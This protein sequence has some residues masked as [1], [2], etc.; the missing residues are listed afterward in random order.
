[1]LS[2]MMMPH[3]SQ[4]AAFREAFVSNDFVKAET[5]ALKTTRAA[6]GS[7]TDTAWSFTLRSGGINSY[8]AARKKTNKTV[9][10]VRVKRC[11]RPSVGIKIWIPDTNCRKYRVSNGDIKHLSNDARVGSMIKLAVESGDGSQVSASGVW[12]PNNTPGIEQI[13][14]H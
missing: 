8:T 2:V 11:S 4:A 12:S 7:T 1:M 13:A 5:P 3:M 14:K 9:V 6:G 10:Y